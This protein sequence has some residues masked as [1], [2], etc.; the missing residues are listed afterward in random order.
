MWTSWIVVDTFIKNVKS[1]SLLDL[2]TK[3]SVV[4]VH[5]SLKNV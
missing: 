5:I 3:I 2:L 4:S 1:L